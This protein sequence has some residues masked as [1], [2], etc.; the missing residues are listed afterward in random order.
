MTVKRIYCSSCGSKLI[1]RNEGGILRDYCEKCN[2]Y[3]YDNPLPV[4]SNIVMKDREILLVKRKNDPFKGLWC[5]PMGFAE[6]GE[7]IEDAALRELAEESGIQGNIID[8]VNA[9]SGYSNTYGDLLFLTFETEW[10][11]GEPEAGDD[12]LE[13]GFFAFDNMPE[14]AF[15]SNINAIGKFIHSKEE[16]WSILDSFSRSVGLNEREHGKSDYLSDNLIRLVEENSEAITRCWL[17][18]IIKA[19]STSTYANF[20]PETSF[21]RNKAVL[22]Q[23]GKWLGGSYS[24]KEIKKFYRELG[25]DRKSEGFSLSEV[26]SALSLTRKCIWEFALSQGLWDKTINIYMVLELERRMM[27]FF[28]KAAYHIARGFEK[29]S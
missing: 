2:T 26:L 15:E 21:S 27:I 11:S 14:M 5:L 25:R 29:S 4:A 17:G 12:A 19:K 1:L 20:D 16:Y 22:R 8:L 10:A 7:S 28:D 18:E 13:I 24:D 6:S 9:E 3:Y 23:F